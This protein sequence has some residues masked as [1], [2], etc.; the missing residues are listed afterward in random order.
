V[1]SGAVVE[2]NGRQS[3]LTPFRGSVPAG[4]STKIIVRKEGF[5]PQEI[6]KIPSIDQPIRVEAVLQQ[7]PPKGYLIVELIGATADVIVEINGKRIEDKSQLS[8]YAVPAHVPVEIKAYSPFSN[9]STQTTVTVD[10]NQKRPVKMILKQ[11]QR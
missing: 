6:E 3:G 9:S 1:P 11:A 5:I 4:V 7:E 8:L 2:I 10:V